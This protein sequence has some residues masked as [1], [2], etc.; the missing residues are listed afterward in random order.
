MLLEIFSYTTYK[1][2]FTQSKMRHWIWSLRFGFGLCGLIFLVPLLFLFHCDP[3]RPWRVP[4]MLVERTFKKKKKKVIRW[5]FF[6]QAF[7]LH[8][9]E[10]FLVGLGRRHP[11]STIYFPFSPPNQT[12]FKKVFFSYF[13]SKV[14]YL[15]Y[16]TSK[17]THPKRLE[18][19]VS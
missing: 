16:F 4:N 10:N 7:S 3:Q 8:F 5:E 11:N 1:S 9:G 17:H 12:H 15:L 13:L 18:M 14:F 6:V 19:L 2:S